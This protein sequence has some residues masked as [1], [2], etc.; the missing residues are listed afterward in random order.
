MYY[1][2][3][4]CRVSRQ[5]PLSVVV[6][7]YAST[8]LAVYELYAEPQSDGDENRREREACVAGPFSLV[9]FVLQLPLTPALGVG[10]CGIAV[11]DALIPKITTTSA[12]A[13]PRDLLYG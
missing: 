1:S 9:M 4:R 10:F 12:V 8:D 3:R 2:I 6:H 11:I 13:R 7:E 5:A